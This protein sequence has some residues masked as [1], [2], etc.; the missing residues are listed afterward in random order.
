MAPT[1]Q[2]TALRAKAGCRDAFREL[3]DRHQSGVLAFLTRRLG[4]ENDAEDVAQDV[5]LRAWRGLAS[6]DPRWRFSTWLYTIA[7]RASVDHARRRPP[8][9]AA[10]DTDSVPEM[11]SAEDDAMK[12]EQA[13][14]LWCVADRILGEDQRTALW[15]KYAEDRTSEEIALVLD[16]SAVAV[17]LLLF[18]ARRRLATHLAEQDASH[19]E[20][21]REVDPRAR[22]LKAS[23]I[24]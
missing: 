13:Q 14:H 9:T 16:R 6:Y 17:R 8:A 11:T 15:L 12:R 1:N 10:V 24:T 21:Q 20:A 7:F 18:R 4:S 23:K 22:S 5:F 19:A 3:V 2:E